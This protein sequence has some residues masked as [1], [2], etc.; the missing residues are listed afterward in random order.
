MVDGILKF[1]GAGEFNKFLLGMAIRYISGS[2]PVLLLFVL[3][4]E[5][6]VELSERALTLVLFYGL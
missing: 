2:D 1:V 5:N 3:S 6:W 4:S